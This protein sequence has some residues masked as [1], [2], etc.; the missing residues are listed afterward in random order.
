MKN[1]MSLFGRV[2][3]VSRPLECARASRAFQGTTYSPYSGTL[4]PLLG[5]IL[6][7]KTDEKRH[8]VIWPSRIV[9]FSATDL[10]SP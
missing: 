10:G 1:D 6:T 5:A 7:M 2:G 4:L 3:G 8:V 9:L